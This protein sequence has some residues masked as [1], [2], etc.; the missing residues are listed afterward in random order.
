M[1]YFHDRFPPHKCYHF[2]VYWKARYFKLEWGIH[3][4]GVGW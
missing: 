2:K 4:I 3:S 1:T